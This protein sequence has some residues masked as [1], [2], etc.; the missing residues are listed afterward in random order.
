M[1]G[2]Q[3][4]DE[5]IALAF[6]LATGRHPSEKEVGVLRQVLNKQ[7]DVYRQNQKAAMQL[8]AV[9]ESPRNEELPVADLAAYT[10]VAS[11]ILNLDETITKG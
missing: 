6:R 5:R 1:T 3:A 2:A 7:M 4:P 11:V 10:I 9:G 8:L